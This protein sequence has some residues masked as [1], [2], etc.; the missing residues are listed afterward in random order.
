MP[1]R[2]GILSPRRGPDS[3]DDLAERRTFIAGQRVRAR[4]VPRRAVGLAL[5]L[6]LGAVLVSS[7]FALLH[8]FLT[9]PRFA[10]TRVEVRGPGWLSEAEAQALAGIEPGQNLFRL[11]AEA[12]PG[13]LERLPRIKSVQVIRSL[14]NRLT[15]LIEERQPFTLAVHA[16]RLYWLD[17][18]GVVLGPEPRAVAPRLPLVTGLGRENPVAGPSVNVEKPRVAV[19]LLRAILRSASPLAAQL[20]EIDVGRADQG[21][22]LYTVDGIEVR[23]GDERWEER[24][25]RLEGV[26]AQLRAQGEPVESIDLRFRDQVVMKPKP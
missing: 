17:E 18:E 7:Q 20:S 9:S 24:L 6:A 14:P 2:W 8:W 25:G 4:R 23:L 19:T 3:L 12:L 26:L 21:P 11:D 5:G 13:R 22:V 1:G 10:V 16:G 15:L